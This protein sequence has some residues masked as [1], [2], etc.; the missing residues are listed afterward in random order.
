MGGRERI[1]ESGRKG[2][3][4]REREEGKEQKR[5]GGMKKYE[6]VGG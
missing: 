6:R 3:N 2:K 1:G 5:L 4:K